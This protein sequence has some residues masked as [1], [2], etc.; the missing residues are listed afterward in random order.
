MACLGSLR[1]RGWHHAVRRWAHDA[2]SRLRNWRLTGPR[3]R[4]RAASQ[5][6]WWYEPAGVSPVFPPE[7]ALGRRSLRHHRHRQR[8]GRGVAGPAPRVDRQAYSDTGARRLPRAQREEL[9][10]ASSLC[11]W[12][13]PSEGDLDELT[14]TD[15]LSG[16]PLLRRRQL[17][18]VWRSAVPSS[19]ARF[20]RSRPRRRHLARVASWL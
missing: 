13:V 3:I 7:V 1:L 5:D 4:V 17:E 6:T 14:G 2:L 9:E 20:R 16:A 10:L 8:T 11:R 19:R 15:F 18:G 12:R